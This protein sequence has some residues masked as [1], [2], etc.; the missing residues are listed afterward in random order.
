MFREIFKVI[1]S[2]NQLFFFVV[3]SFCPW[4]LQIVFF[5]F[6]KNKQVA[7]ASSSTEESE[8]RKNKHLTPDNDPTPSE[9]IEEQQ[10]ESRLMKR[11]VL[12]VYKNMPPPTTQKSPLKI[13]REENL[14]SM[15][16]YDH[17]YV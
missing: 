16:C 2:S 8:D 12:P 9:E 7:F 10:F 13:R 5:F 15:V 17:T 6:F 4:I 1:L 14:E 11:P 3:K